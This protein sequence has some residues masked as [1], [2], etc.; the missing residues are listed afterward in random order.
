M[1]RDLKY[2][3]MNEK[4]NLPTT[5]AIRPC[6]HTQPTANSLQANA[7]GEF[8]GTSCIADRY[9]IFNKSLQLN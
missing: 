5:I 1:R 2:N 6:Q 9:R 8:A 3:Q 4:R 7:H